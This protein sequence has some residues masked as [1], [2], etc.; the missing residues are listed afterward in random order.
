VGGLL[1]LS[2]TPVVSWSYEVF[3]RRGLWLTISAA[4]RLFRKGFL[5]TRHRLGDLNLVVVNTHLLANYDQDW[6]PGNR[7]VAHQADELAQLS[8]ALEKVDRQAFLVA[9]GDFN[10]P[11]DSPLLARFVSDSGLTSVFGDTPPPATLRATSGIKPLAIDHIF[12]RAPEGRA[13][14][15]T[16]A[17][18]FEDAVE[19]GP[20]VT[21][22]ASD[23]LAVMATFTV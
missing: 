11:A 17:T 7:F 10:V 1:T 14:G 23:H 19:L 12:Y 16:A 6:S 22:F 4:D 13:V 8:R 5:T 2:R 20:G 9:A 21:G 3:D 15:A 18:L